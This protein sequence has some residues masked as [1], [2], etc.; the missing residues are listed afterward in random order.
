MFPAS[1]TLQLFPLP[2]MLL[3]R[4]F[5]SSFPPSH[6]V[7]CSN[8][9]LVKRPSL[10]I[11]YN[12]PIP[13]PGIFPLPY[14]IF[15][16]NT[17]STW[18]VYVLAYWYIDWLPLL[19]Y[20]LREGKD[21]VFLYCYNPAPDLSYHI[22]YCVAVN[23]FFFLYWDLGLFHGQGAR[24]R[25]MVCSVLS[26]NLEEE[27]K[28]NFLWARPFHSILTPTLQDR[29]YYFF[30]TGVTII[31]VSWMRKEEIQGVRWLPQGHRASEWW[32]QGF[33]PG[34]PLPCAKLS[35]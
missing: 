31:L 13:N 25:L 23:L 17:F 4:Y 2:E 33:D 34:W 8:F 10:V 9:I 6:S 27:K 12:N 15:P 3:L 1:G 21:I 5:R 30:L 29:H 16:Q 35:I 18:H 22:L 7:F 19:E 32:S 26:H 28:M 20:K 14:F 11:L 24:F